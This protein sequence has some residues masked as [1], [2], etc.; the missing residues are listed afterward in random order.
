MRAT[1]RQGA[2]GDDVRAAQSLLAHSGY[3]PGAVDGVFGARTV[4]AVVAFQRDAGLGVDGAIGSMTWDALESAVAPGVREASAGADERD[5]DADALG[6][7]FPDIPGANKQLFEVE[8]VG[9]IGLE[10]RPDEEGTTVTAS[11]SAR[12]NAKRALHVSDGYLLVGLEGVNFRDEGRTD[13]QIVEPFTEWRNGKTWEGLLD[14]KYRLAVTAAISH[15]LDMFLVPQSENI[16]FREFT[17]AK[18][19][20]AEIVFS[21]GIPPFLIV[22]RGLPGFDVSWKA[23]HREDKALPAFRHVDRVT[24]DRS[25][26]PLFEQGVLV[27]FESVPEFG[28]YEVKLPVKVELTPGTYRVVVALD[29]GKGEV[30]EAVQVIVEPPEPEVPPTQADEPTLR[31]GDRDDKPGH[32]WVTYLQNMLQGRGYDPGGIDGVFLGKTLSAARAF[33]SNEKDVNGE[34]LKVDGIVGFQTWAALQEETARKPSTDGRVPHTYVE[35]GPEARWAM[36]GDA[37]VYSNDEDVLTLFGLSTG[38]VPVRLEHLEGF[39]LNLTLPSGQ[40]VQLTGSTGGLS[41]PFEAG[42]GEVLWIQRQG[43]R[44][45][46]GPGTYS[47]TAFM[48]QHLGSDNVSGTFDVA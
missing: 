33:Q 39:T 45:L 19:A 9:H 47:F 37:D 27:P 1:L 32:G 10:T 6:P 2:R 3:D 44:S 14:G 42:P 26:E 5:G 15:D 17:I 35:E 38:N 12:H 46:G 25:E 7:G 8:I 34:P 20:P 13:V 28:E 24:L 31:Y 29:D 41:M 30:A 48:P 16:D 4:A 36:E 22:N 23:R 18:S 11:W 43:I 40:V 21:H